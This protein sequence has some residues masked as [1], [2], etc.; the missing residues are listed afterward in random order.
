MKCKLCGAQMDADMTVCP[1]CGAE[2][3][4]VEGAEAAPETAAAPV[5]PDVPEMPAE[6]AAEAPETEPAGMDGEETPDAE[7]SEETDEEE[8]AAKAGGKSRSSGKKLG[9]LIAVVVVVVAALIYAVVSIFGGSGKNGASGDDPLAMNHVDAEGNFVP[10]SYTKD[11]AEITEDEMNTVVATCGD[12]ELTNAQLSYYYWQ[13]VSAY[14]SYASMLGVDFTKPLSEQMYDEAGTATWEDLFL[15]SAMATFWQTAAVCQA[16]DEAGY[17]LDESTTAYLDSLA[18]GMAEEAEANDYESQDAY[19]Q[20]VYGPYTSMDSYLEFGRQM[21]TVQGYL[22][23]LY[24]GIEYTD[25]DLKAYFEENQE[26]YAAQ[27]LSLD[28]PNMVNV[29]HILI[30]PVA[31]E[32]AETDENGNAIL[33][34]QNWADA[35][36]KAEEIYDMWLTG[37]A[38]EDS[39]AELA[40]EYSEDPGSASNGGLYEEVYPGQMVDTFNDWCFD[41]SRQVGDSGIVE[42]TYGYHIMYFS[43]T[44]DHPYWYVVAEQDYVNGRQ[45]EILNE[46]V[47]S[48]PVE[49]DYDK[50]VL[51]NTGLLS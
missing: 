48:R 23:Q 43:G 32:N 29:R 20:S 46:I 35:K 9:I 33:T 34:D 25:D 51:A 40:G 36:A 4:P 2:A 14:G 22:N 28:D 31:D 1:L 3:D 7:P 41:A 27:G 16:A 5:T 37:E 45:Q 6:P 44:C 13:Q 18:E 11:N 12:Y 17:T 39:F 10:H 38:T 15:Q 24:S 21:M 30:T 49:V 50:V 19:I 47:D 26:Q 42:T 8:T